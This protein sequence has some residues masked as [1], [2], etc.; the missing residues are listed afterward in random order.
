MAK[1]SNSTIARALLTT[2]GAQ[3]ST[4]QAVTSLAAYLVEERRL[5]DLSAIMRDIERHL[6]I[7]DGTL[8]VHAEVAHALNDT[9]KRNLKNVFAEH[10]G[11][12]D[13]IIEQTIIYT[14]KLI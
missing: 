5:G 3:K 13:I 14:P 10:T 6:L 2:I 7:H 1:E 4:K 11:A 9:Q 8:V 12:K